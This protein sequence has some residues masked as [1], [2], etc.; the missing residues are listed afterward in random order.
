MTR[1]MKPVTTK[2]Q[3]ASRVLT[4][5]EVQRVGGAMTQNELEYWVRGLPLP[6]HRPGPGDHHKAPEGGLL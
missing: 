6:Q 3:N 5:D 2:V 4:P 1:N